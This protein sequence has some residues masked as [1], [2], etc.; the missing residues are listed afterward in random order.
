MPDLVHQRVQHDLADRRPVVAAGNLE[1]E[2]T[3]PVFRLQP[4]DQ[5]PHLLTRFEAEA[6]DL[7]DVLA[8]PAA[9]FAERFSEDELRVPQLGTEDVQHERSD[10]VF[11]VAGETH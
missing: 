1:I 8:W 3:R 4:L 2:D 11:A 7:I 6:E 5:L 10:A 9:I